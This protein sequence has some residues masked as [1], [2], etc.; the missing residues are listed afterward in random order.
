MVWVLL[1]IT[2]MVIQTVIVHL[3]VI[4]C[5]SGVLFGMCFALWFGVMWWRVVWDFLGGF[6]GW[7][8]AW[9]AAI[10]GVS[11]R[12]PMHI[13][14]VMLSVTVRMMCVSI[15]L[16]ALWTTPVISSV[17]PVVWPG[18]AYVGVMMT[19]AVISVRMGLRPRPA[20][21]VP[22]FVMVGWGWSGVAATMR[23]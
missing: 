16:W 14:S 1:W 8:R 6:V 22:V 15:W 2:G 4:Y 23:F 20:V 10:S 21:S 5:D 18:M 9:S 3:C 13:W 11:W 19:F 12:A 17:I 7:S